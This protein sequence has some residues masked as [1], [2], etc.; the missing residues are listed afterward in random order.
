MKILLS[1]LHWYNNNNVW[2]TGFIRRGNM[3]ITDNKL[4]NQ[5]SGIGTIS[6]FE[7][8]LKKANGQFSVILKISGEIW[9]ATDRL[10]NYPLFYTWLNGDFILSDDCYKLTEELP[11]K[12]LN[13]AAVDSF[14]STGYVLNNLTLINDVF[15]I[16]AGEYIRAGDILSRK[17]YYEIASATVTE[18]DFET[19]AFELNNL[20]SVVFQDH[21]EALSH[22]FIAIP[23]SG[24]FDSRLVA[25]MC[26]KYHPENVLCYTYGTSN[27]RE[28]APAEKVA[29]RLGFK[30]INIIYDSELIKGFL[31]DEIFN[32]Y[33]PSVSN[34]SSMFFL[35]EYF[36]VKYLKENRIVPEDCVFV[37]GFSG[38][39]LAGGYLTTAMDNKIEKN[40][41]ADLILKEKFDL[42]KLSS[43]KESYALKLICE[44][45]P[46]GLSDAWKVFENWEYKEWQS[47][48]IVNSAKVF[49]FFGYRY[50]FPLYD[51]LL[52]DFFS[53]LD[54]NFKLNKKLYDYVLTEYIF[55]GLNLNLSNELNPVASQKA[56]QRFKERIKR[57]IPFGIKELFIKHQS[58]IFYDKITKVMLEELGSDLIKPKQSNYYN[59]YIIQ[60]YLLKTRQLFKIK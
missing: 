26:A 56:F 46:E 38:D 15:Q 33:Y 1:K 55:K 13:E 40:K 25:S 9:A 30:W 17:F 16:E 4:L 36:A 12:Y 32:N 45:V 60:W 24:G 27:N 23:L 31:H 50:V 35:Q 34:L 59:S 8:I 10:R 43:K 14:L 42:I 20:I 21:L 44:K 57:F 41:I 53:N 3:Y 39:M 18:K 54:F 58:P 51:N 47:K 7:E 6:E 19:R 28:V 37:N 29:G 5:F 52:L 11:E 22:K 2:V 49:P 48:F